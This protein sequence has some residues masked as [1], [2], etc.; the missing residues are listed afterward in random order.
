MRRD[1]AEPQASVATLCKSGN[2]AVATRCG[3]TR[4]DVAPVIAELMGERRR[5]TAGHR[6]AG[7]GRERSIT[8]RHRPH[9]GRPTGTDTPR[10]GK[11][12]PQSVSRTLK[13]LEL[14]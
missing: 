1:E 13:R 11:W 2:A 14:T 12:H 6:V 8:A 7:A 5:V 4:R 9:A 10:G 3:G